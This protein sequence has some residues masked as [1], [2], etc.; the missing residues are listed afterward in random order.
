MSPQR[1]SKSITR[2]ETNFVTS[3][4]GTRSTCW[5]LKQ[6][7]S[8][9]QRFKP[10]SSLRYS[11]LDSNWSPATLPKASCINWVGCPFL[12]LFLFERKKKNCSTFLLLATFFFSTWTWE[13]VEKVMKRLMPR[14][15]LTLTSRLWLDLC[16]SFF[17]IAFLQIFQSA[18]VRTLWRWHWNGVPACRN[19]KSLSNLILNLVFFSFLFFSPV[20]SF[21]K[22]CWNCVYRIDA[23][24]DRLKGKKGFSES[25]KNFLPTLKSWGPDCLYLH[26]CAVFPVC[27]LFR[28]S[29]RCV[30][31]GKQWISQYTVC[32]QNMLW[33]TFQWSRLSL[34]LH[35]K[36]VAVH[37]GCLPVWIYGGVSLSK[38]WWLVW[39]A[40]A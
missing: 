12:L 40:V 5:T 25:G 30:I 18:C 10:K 27:W 37:F 11:T 33:L 16:C 14:G 26:P 1:I 4:G 9:L 24:A 7:F 38:G 23:G 6:T 20:V 3:C 39:V 31:Y 13:E 34:W 8:A 32:L 29:L 17:F 22:P 35:A 19:V 28:C 2:L 36:I 15:R 21:L